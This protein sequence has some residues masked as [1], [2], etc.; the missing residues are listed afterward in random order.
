MQSWTINSLEN[1]NYIFYN[2]NQSTVNSKA[3]IKFYKSQPNHFH[4]FEVAKTFWRS[5]NEN[6]KFVLNA[7]VYHYKNFSG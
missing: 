2:Y 4:F 1:I 7:T 6:L 5:L 3:I